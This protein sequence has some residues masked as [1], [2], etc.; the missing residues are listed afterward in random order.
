MTA[1]NSIRTGLVGQLIF[2]RLSNGPKTRDELAQ[3]LYANQRIVAKYVALLMKMGLVAGGEYARGKPANPV[4]LTEKG[5]SFNGRLP[6]LHE[7]EGGKQR[8]RLAVVVRTEEGGIVACAMRAG[9][10]FV[11]DL[12]RNHAKAL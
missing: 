9:P 3:L 6:S 2:E 10:A 1:K 8:N 7:A 12:G 4:H 11:F 5:K